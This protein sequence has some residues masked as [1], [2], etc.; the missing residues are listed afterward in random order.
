MTG[1]ESTE[2]LVAVERECLARFRQKAAELRAVSPTM[3]AQVAF[4]RA[5]TMLPKTADKYQFA[6][7]L[8]QE[9]GHAALPLR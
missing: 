2:E 6:R 1:Y 3:T 9:R 5:V 7:A 4:C 8:L